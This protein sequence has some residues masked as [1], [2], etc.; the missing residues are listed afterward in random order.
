MKAYILVD[1]AIEQTKV[2]TEVHTAHTAGK[3][4]WVD[5]GPRDTEADALLSETFRLHPL[6][7]E[8]IWLGRS[9]PKLNDYGSYLHL[10]MEGPRR[11]PEGAQTQ[12]ALWTLDVVLGATFLITHHDDL[13]L[14][15]AIAPVLAR[16]PRLLEEG[17]A[18]LLHRILDHVVDRFLPVIDR[19]GGRLD[20]V[21]RQVIE[22]ATDAQDREL[23]PTIFGLKRSLQDLCRIASHQREILEQLARGGV[24]AL[25]P[26]TLPYYRDVSIHFVRVAELADTYR[27]RVLNVLDA[28]FSV[29]SNVMNRSIKRLTVIS[30]VLL[31]LNLMAGIYGMNFRRMPG[32]YSMY[33][34]PVTLGL[35]ALLAAGVL[36]GFKRRGWM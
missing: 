34:F 20:E 2:A 31:P 5:L 6:V 21:E 28:N 23:T 18:W 19:L 7:I 13:V 25:P 29:Q 26:A 32:L 15:E 10:A 1:G 16:T 14:V 24:E 4:M 30:T 9:V 3:L 8:G 35:M 11:A 22:D 33:G 36:V 17:P 27:D 12:L